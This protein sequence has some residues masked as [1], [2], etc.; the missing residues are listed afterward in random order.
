M[1]IIL[2]LFA[3]ILLIF[4]SCGKSDERDYVKDP[5][6]KEEIEKSVQKTYFDQ[7]G[8]PKYELWQ[9]AY[10]ALVDGELTVIDDILF[11]SVLVQPETYSRR[12][13]VYDFEKH[14]W[15]TKNQ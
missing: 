12:K 8:S 5:L 10:N 6:T 13:T 11:D 1:A 15:T 3:E 9:N 14:K 7:N 4:I 2:L